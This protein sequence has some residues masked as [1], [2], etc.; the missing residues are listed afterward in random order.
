MEK[1]E[2]Y[3]KEQYREEDPRC[4]GRAEKGK[5]EKKRGE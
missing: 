1:Y 5:T 3:L 2:C 4:R